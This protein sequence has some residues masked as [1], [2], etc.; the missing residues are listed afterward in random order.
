MKLLPISI[1]AV[2][3]LGLTS[4]SFF[5]DD[6]EADL[7]AESKLGNA[8]Y[9]DTRNIKQIILAV[10]PY[11]LHEET[12]ADFMRRIDA[13]PVKKDWRTGEDELTV[14][15]DGN[16]PPRRFVLDRKRQWLLAFI[17][18]SSEG[19]PSIYCFQRNQGKMELVRHLS[20][21]N[22]RI[23]SSKWPE[24]LGASSEWLVQ[25]GLLTE[26]PQPAKKR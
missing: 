15:A 5:S 22:M 11:T 7:M 23:P 19:G 8:A 18:G 24:Y 17:E 1:L 2:T 25:K 26:A 13:A 20:L 9:W 4:C 6:P 3:A 10:D 21:T 12:T 16:Y 14:D